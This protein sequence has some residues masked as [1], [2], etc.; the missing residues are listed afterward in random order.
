MSPS[1]VI[2]SLRC[3][4]S[5]LLASGPLGAECET[6]I[7]MCLYTHMTVSR[8]D[9][10]NVQL[11]WQTINFTD[12]V[13]KR[14]KSSHLMIQREVE[15]REEKTNSSAW[16]KSE[17]L[18][19]VAQICG[20]RIYQKHLS[21]SRIYKRSH[22]GVTTAWLR[23]SEGDWRREDEVGIGCRKSRVTD[24]VTG[25]CSKGV[26]GERNQVWLEWESRDLFRPFHP[27]QPIR[28]PGSRRAKCKVGLSFSFSFFFFNKRSKKQ[29]NHC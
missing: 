16:W 28:P 10:S 6:L 17:P 25:N 29:K 4:I 15:L 22:V 14:S 5:V 7:K 9:S 13:T 24:V 23:W 8:R 20:R 3:F 2:L 21:R 19:K 12:S 26:R 1:N 11:D 18:N 27:N